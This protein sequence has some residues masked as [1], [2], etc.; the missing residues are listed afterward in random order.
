MRCAAASVIASVVATAI[1]C[2]QPRFFRNEQVKVVGEIRYG[3]TSDKIEYTGK[4]LYRAIYFDGHAGDNV[5][6]KVTSIN[7]QTLS[8]LTDSRYKP[9]VSSFGSHVTAVLPPSAEPYPDRYFVIIQEERRKPATFTVTLEKTGTNAAAGSADYLMCSEDSDCIAVPKAGCCNNGYKEAVN[10]DRVDSYR[11]ANTCKIAHPMC[12]QFIV[13][14]KRVAQCNR[15]SHRCEM[16][17]AKA[18]GH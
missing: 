8:A 11:A 10:K 13:E 5:D 12:A 14:D 9:I 7:G 2:G 4:P 1:V 6:I 16:V 18:S 3:Q 17:D 15:T